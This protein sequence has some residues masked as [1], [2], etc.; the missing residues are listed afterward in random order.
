MKQQNIEELNAEIKKVGGTTT[1]TRQVV[2]WYNG[3]YMVVRWY[4]GTAVGWDG[5]TWCVVYKV[6]CVYELHGSQY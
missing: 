6:V 4:G 5:G 2:R 1:S 3:I